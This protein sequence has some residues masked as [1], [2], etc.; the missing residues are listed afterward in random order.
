M[1][2]TVKGKCFLAMGVMWR[3][4][5]AKGHGLALKWLPGLQWQAEELPDGIT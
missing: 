5:G 4:E 3:G 1:L 2:N